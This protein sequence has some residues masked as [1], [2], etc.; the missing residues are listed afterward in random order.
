[1]ELSIRGLKKVI[2]RIRDTL[3]S[4]L[5]IVAFKMNVFNMVLILY[6]R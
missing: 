4:I 1:V 5:R 6:R 3:A 2:R